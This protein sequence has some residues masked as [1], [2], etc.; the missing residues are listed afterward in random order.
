MQV[1]T[2]FWRMDATKRVDNRESKCAHRQMPLEGAQIAPMDRI[3]IALVFA[4]CAMKHVQNAQPLAARLL[5]L[6]ALQGTIRLLLI[7]M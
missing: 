4:H 2:S 7:H 3:Q 1:G 6:S 5:V